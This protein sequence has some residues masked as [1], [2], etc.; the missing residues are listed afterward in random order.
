MRRCCRRFWRKCKPIRFAVS[1]NKPYGKRP[2]GSPRDGLC[3]GIGSWG[4]NVA[5]ECRWEVKCPCA[6]PD[7]DFR[8]RIRIGQTALEFIWI[9]KPLNCVKP[10]D[11]RVG[12]EK[13]GLEQMTA[14]YNFERDVLAKCSAKGLSR[15][16]KVL[17]FGTIQPHSADPSSVVQYLILELAD[18]DIRSFVEWGQ[19]FQTAWTLRIMHNVTVALR[20]LHSIKIAHQDLKPSNVLIFNRNSSKLT[21]LGRAFD[22]HAK[23]PFDSIPF[24]GDLTYAPPEVLYGCIPHEWKTRRLGGDIYLLGSLFAFFCANVSMTHLLSSRL[25]QKYHWNKWT[26]K[27]DEVLPYIQF[28]FAQIIREFRGNIHPKFSNDI[29]EMVRHLCN[30]DPTLRGHPKNI[31]ANSNKYS[32]ERYVSLLDLLARKAE[33]SLNHKDPIR[34]S[35]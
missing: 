24:A 21:D 3:P 11:Y 2:V 27:Y 15:I 20:Q 12:V 18:H 5:H 34:R 23:S 9:R 22:R 33:W 6:S 25:D 16:V 17:D 19:V 4:R 31:N 32:L 7:F 26:G 29:A 30:P 1:E 28:V 14:A 35:Q 8:H 10:T 13:C